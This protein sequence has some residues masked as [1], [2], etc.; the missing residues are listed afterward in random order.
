[1]RI[2]VIRYRPGTVDSVDWMRLLG[3][4]CTTLSV[5][6][7]WPQV[8]R[9]YRQHTVDGIAPNGTL[10][11]AVASGL[12]M[13]YGLARGDVAISVANAAVVLAMVLIAAQQIRHGTLTR[14]KAAITAV[15]AV[16]VGGIG[17]AISPTAV[18]WLA[19]AAGATSVLPQTVHVLRAPTLDGVSVPMYA[20]LCLTTLSWAV[21]GLALGDPLVVATNLLVL[22]CA[23]LV[24][25]RTWVYQRGAA[26]ATAAA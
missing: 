22:P 9:V 16:V 25:S 18:G 21:Y 13:L 12:W 11:G 6:F 24:M 19:I 1:M 2:A 20:L 3:L 7:V 4:W 8:A 26:P 10:H 15:G 5:A 14:Q 23:G 17:L